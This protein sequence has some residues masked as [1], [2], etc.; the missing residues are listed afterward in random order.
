[1]A[2]NEKT[3]A[4]ALDTKQKIKG[5]ISKITIGGAIV[6]LG[7]DQLPGILHIS[8]LQKEHLTKVEDAVEIGQEVE[9]WVRRAKKD[10]IELTMIEPLP[11]EWREM[12][13]DM[14]VKGKIERLESYGAFVDIGAERP[15]LV[16]VSEIAH[17]YVK[18]P[19][20][21]VKVDDE[22]DVMILEV[23]R[24][25]KQI[26]LSMKATLPEPAESANQP[27]RGR[28]GGK[29]RSSKKSVEAMM[30]ELEG[31]EPKA[32]EHTAMEMAW[33]AALDRADNSNGKPKEEKKAKKDNAQEEILSRTLEE[34][35]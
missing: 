8:Q 1:M 25:K 32:P 2:E 9:M 24:R 14:T 13:P 30:A 33:Q 27:R 22:V 29:R 19:S 23:N 35:K 21:V 6:D 11:L 28:G 34:R 17:G 10:R 18:D 26:R 4:N 7:A 20:Q 31:D 15:G 3:Q 16:H 5:T 12:K